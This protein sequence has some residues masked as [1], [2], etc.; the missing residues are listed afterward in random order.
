MFCDVSIRM[1]QHK[2]TILLNTM[3]DCLESQS[4]EPHCDI[5]KLLKLLIEEIDICL[6]FN[7]Q[8][9]DRIAILCEEKSIAIPILYEQPSISQMI[10]KSS[11]PDILKE[12]TV[13]AKNVCRCIEIQC[14]II[15]IL[16]QNNFFVQFEKNCV[17]KMLLSQSQFILGGC[18]HMS[19][20]F[21][22]YCDISDLIE[23]IF[24]QDVVEKFVST[25]LKIIK[26]EFTKND[27]MKWDDG[28]VPTTVS[29]KVE[30]KWLK[31]E[32]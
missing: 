26:L 4:N 19:A 3:C 24:Y 18:K 5:I 21:F 6:K 17:E 11:I 31:A 22:L 25:D 16:I 23:N 8:I 7:H 20:T 1:V 9:F 10:T 15:N 2:L 32:L 30:K 27:W 29:K 28:N 13:F 12:S 14:M